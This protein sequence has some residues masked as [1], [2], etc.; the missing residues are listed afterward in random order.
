MITTPNAP[1]ARAEKQGWS[2]APGYYCGCQLKCVGLNDSFNASVTNGGKDCGVQD[3]RGWNKTCR[4][5][6]LIEG[7]ADD[8]SAISDLGDSLEDLENDAN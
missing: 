6:M 5:W 4:I 3:T 7:D 2:C 1:D 8:A